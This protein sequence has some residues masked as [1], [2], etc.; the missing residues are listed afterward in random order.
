VPDQPDGLDG[1]STARAH[2][3]ILRNGR[4][5][6]RRQFEFHFGDGD[7]ESILAALRPY[8]N[9]DGGF[10]SALEPDLRGPDSQPVHAVFALELL[11]EIDRF[12]DPM[13]AKAVDWMA[14]V[15]RDD[16][17]VPWVLPGANLYPAA[18]WWTGPPTPWDALMPTASVAG[19]L[20]KRKV[21]HPWLPDAV[22]YCWEAVESIADGEGFEFHLVR[23]AGTFLRFVEDRNRAEPHIARIG[24]TVRKRGMVETYAAAGPYAKTSLAWAPDPDSCWRGIFTEAEINAALD[25]MLALQAPDGAWPLGFPNTSAASEF[26]WKPHLALRNLLT[27]RAYGRL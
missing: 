10:G 6:E 17:A 1:N 13:V 9:A 15:S 14:S 22:A 16:G 19:L 2:D 24:R 3:F 20:L 26:E 21:E 11:D 8:Q 18:P 4:L 23:P 25:G 27:L 12:D 5:L 7:A